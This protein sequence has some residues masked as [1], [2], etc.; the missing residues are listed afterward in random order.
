MKEDRVEALSKPATIN[1]R[2]I[3]LCADAD[4]DF[5]PGRI[6]SEDFIEQLEMLSSDLKVDDWEFVMSKGAY[7]AVKKFAGTMLDKLTGSS[8]EAADSTSE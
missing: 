7:R 1:P 2:V 3:G 8:E 5:G 4:K 6:S